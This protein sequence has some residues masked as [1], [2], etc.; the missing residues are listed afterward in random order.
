MLQETLSM[1]QETLWPLF[2]PSFDNVRSVLPGFLADSQHQRHG[3]RSNLLPQF[4]VLLET[5]H[6]GGDRSGQF[7]CGVI[8]GG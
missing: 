6:I 5:T 7:G 1:L 4:E 2:P 8:S 3:L